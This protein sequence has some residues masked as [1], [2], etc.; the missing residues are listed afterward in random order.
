[1]SLPHSVRAQTARGT[2]LPA[3]LPPDT[4]WRARRILPRWPPTPRPLPLRQLSRWNGRGQIVGTDCRT[5]LRDIGRSR[6]KISGATSKNDIGFPFAS[7]A[8]SH[9]AT[10]RRTR[11]AVRENQR[12]ARFWRGPPVRIGRN[13]QGPA[14]AQATSIRAGGHCENDG[15][16]NRR[17]GRDAQRHSRSR[18][19]AITGSV[20]AAGHTEVPDFQRPA[21]ELPAMRMDDGRQ[22]MDS[23]HPARDPITAD[24]GWRVDHLGC[25]A[26]HP[27]CA[28]GRLGRAAD[29]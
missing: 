13:S 20:P 4:P 16:I 5:D 21:I 15:H 28:A 17:R 24:P 23:P 22:A 11:W 6:S 27:R 14:Q 2:S 3:S 26:D 18:R 7:P 8:A 1:M 9:D 29:P 25:V 19:Y 12:Q 10:R